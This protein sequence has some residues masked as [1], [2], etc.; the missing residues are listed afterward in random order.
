M[1]QCF[2][3]V[4]SQRTGAD[5]ACVDCLA[6]CFTSVSVAG[7]ENQHYLNKGTLGWYS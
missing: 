5:F 1:F 4:H 7:N 6:V 3:P 2:L